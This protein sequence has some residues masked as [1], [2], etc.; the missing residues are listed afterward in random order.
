MCSSR[1]L[2][3]NIVKAFYVF[4]DFTGSYS[5]K[6]SIDE[7]VW[8]FEGLEVNKAFEAFK[9]FKVFLIISNLS[10]VAQLV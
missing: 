6:F 8:F 2:Q 7:G 5:D 1:L 3:D 4:K 10:S 9:V